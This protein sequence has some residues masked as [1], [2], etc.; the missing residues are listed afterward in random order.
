MNRSVMFLHVMI[1]VFCLSSPLDAV[2]KPSLS[3][4]EHLGKLLFF[5]F[6]GMPAEWNPEG[7]AFANLPLSPS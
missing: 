4:K 7:S 2:E 1:F 3:P 5:P 6:Y